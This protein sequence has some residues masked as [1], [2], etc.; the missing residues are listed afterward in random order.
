MNTV[1]LAFKLI[2]A[3]RDGLKG[4]NGDV[5]KGFGAADVACVRVDLEKGFDL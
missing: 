1:L 3:I 5:L 2:L 4:F